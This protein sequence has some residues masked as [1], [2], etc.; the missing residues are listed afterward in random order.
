MG[1]T[2]W[3]ASIL[4]KFENSKA[5]RTVIGIWTDRKLMR[6]VTIKVSWP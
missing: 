2:R 6:Y 5:W 1:T 3:A 4:A